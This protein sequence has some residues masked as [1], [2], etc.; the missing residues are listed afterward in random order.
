VTAE[1]TKTYGIL[2][3]RLL[4]VERQVL[5]TFPS[6]EQDIKGTGVRADPLGKKRCNQGTNDKKGG[7]DHR[8]QTRAL[9][10]RA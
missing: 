5:V 1:Q 10:E 8:R 4:G 7:E 3:N 2:R 6:R 9:W